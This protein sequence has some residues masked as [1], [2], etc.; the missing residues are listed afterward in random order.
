[1]ETQTAFIRTDGTVELHAITDVD[2]H[3]SFVVCP[4]NAE[5]DDPFRFYHP[6]NEFCFF[7]LWML[8][9]HILD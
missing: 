6:F 2:M 9:V 7:K 4:R 8:I 1:M 3:F 5:C